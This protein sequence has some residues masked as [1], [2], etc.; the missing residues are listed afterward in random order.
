MRFF[1]RDG[2]VNYRCLKEIAMTMSAEDSLSTF[3]AHYH[4]N[5]WFVN[6]C[7]M[8]LAVSLYCFLFCGIADSDLSV[9]SSFPYFFQFPS[10]IVTPQDQQTTKSLLIPQ[11]SFVYMSQT[12]APLRL[13]PEECSETR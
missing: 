12:G 8:E 11:P 7:L 3:R 9:C 10:W 13:L 6:T 1:R 5:C 2:G 4:E